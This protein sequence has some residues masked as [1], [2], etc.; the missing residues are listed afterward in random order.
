M[1]VLVSRNI[2]KDRGRSKQSDTDNLIGKMETQSERWMG[3]YLPAIIG[4][5][6]SSLAESAARGPR[7]L[8]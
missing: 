8:T 7:P 5:V 1:H 4:L 6:R 3:G 2:I